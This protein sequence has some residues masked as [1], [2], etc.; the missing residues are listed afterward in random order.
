MKNSLTNLD[1]RQQLSIKYVR[2]ESCNTCNR[3]GAGI[4]RPAPRAIV[5][6]VRFLWK[7]EKL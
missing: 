3:S 7:R 4:Q 5:G 2:N 6:I 1:I